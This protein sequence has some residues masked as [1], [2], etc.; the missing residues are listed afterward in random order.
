MDNNDQ[1]E[2]LADE[3]SLA[4]D[5][6][7]D[8]RLAAE[9][10][11]QQLEF[12]K[13]QTA[14]Q[15]LQ[16]EKLKAELHHLQADEKNIAVANVRE[17]LKLVL[18]IGLALF[19][20][21]LIVL[22]G[23]AVYSAARSRSVVVD[24][25]SVPPDFAAQGNT[26]VVVAGGFLDQLQALQAATR[27]ASAH[28]N[29]EDAWSND[30]KV[31]IPDT[32]VS[33]GEVLTYLRGWLGND[34]HIGGNIVRSG[35]NIVLSVRGNGLPAKSFSGA[36]ADLPKLT[37]QAAEYIYGQ[38]EPY[39]YGA[40]L[41]NTG[42]D[43]DA[44]ELVRRIYPSVGANTR[45][46]LLTIW[47]NALL[48]LGDV[49][50]ALAKYREETRL[51]PE[52]WPAYN[53]IINAQID[54]GDEEGALQTAA[55]MEAAVRRKSWSSPAVRAI[56]FQ[57]QDFL[58]MDLPALHA[59]TV[60]DMESNHGFGDLTV[61]D[62]PGDAEFLARM[63]EAGAAEQELETSPGAGSDPYV[64]A[65]TYYVRGLIG[66]LDGQYAAAYPSLA[67]ADKLV[68]QSSFVA[69]SFYAPPACLAGLTAE[70]IG[71]H[72]VADADIKRG[73]H[74][75]DCYRFKADIADHRGQWAEAQKDYAA[76]IAL[77]PSMPAG[78]F[79][80]GD[81]LM[82]HRDFVGAAAL[83]AKA[84]AE[85]PHWADP[86]KRWGDALAARGEFSA[87]IAKYEEAEKY[88]PRWGS[89]QIAWG[90]ALDRLGH[91][92]EAV[93]KYRAALGMDIT[94]D[95]HWSLRGCCG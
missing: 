20:V 86:L 22:I 17:R 82:R 16:A 1:G 57:N 45:A 60:A 63:H 4:D 80:W 65:Q 92:D 48:D 3:M 95:E 31:N 33:L 39:L 46:D 6:K 62:A 54:S 38:S 64:I 75:E 49:A 29:V 14:L 44:A 41:E 23:T 83:F 50:G 90:H 13:A 28:H 32:G 26:G 51:N 42:R 88:A 89:L 66:V 81:A 85:G 77:A 35:D 87:A 61:Q 59:A 67:T 71:Q 94:G 2:T 10:H 78:Y 9:L 72:D 8:P 93:S 58:W 70:M 76:A 53:N 12:L 34:I 55:E 21:A 40:Y 43:K 52:A 79:S 56:D 84:N 91:H 18:D 68:S 27:S 24:A 7:G 69:S 74:F 73:G 30:I 5:A 11:R 47:G 15:A 25:F 36:P 37:S 19:G